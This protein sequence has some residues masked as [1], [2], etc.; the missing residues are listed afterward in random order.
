MDSLSAQLSS[1]AIEMVHK[2]FPR[3]IG[4][5]VSTGTRTLHY[6]AKGVYMYRHTPIWLRLHPYF[7]RSIHACALLSSESWPG[8]NMGFTIAAPT[9]PTRV[10]MMNIWIHI[11]YIEQ[12]SR[13]YHCFGHTSGDPRSRW[14]VFLR[15][16]RRLCGQLH[17]QPSYLPLFL[18]PLPFLSHHGVALQI[19]RSRHSLWLLALQ[20]VLPCCLS[21]CAVFLDSGWVLQRLRG[22]CEGKSLT[23]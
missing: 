9:F 4:Q 11:M 13:L 23:Y 6:L 17:Q 3:S 14:A 12:Y 8:R 7:Y 21:G 20:T 2:W 19:R 16:L 10:H 15:W 18:H 5:S 1:N 22:S